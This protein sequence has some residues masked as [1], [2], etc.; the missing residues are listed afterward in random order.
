VFGQRYVS[1]DAIST[2]KM[3]KSGFDPLQAL[4]ADIV[5]DEN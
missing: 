2:A 5:R 4:L 3:T 1:E